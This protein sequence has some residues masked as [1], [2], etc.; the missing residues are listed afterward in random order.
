MVEIWTHLVTQFVMNQTC[1]YICALLV[2]YAITIACVYTMAILAYRISRMLIILGVNKML[3][4]MWI[5][6]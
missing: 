2:A 6:A 1:Q 4:N 5:A 3:E